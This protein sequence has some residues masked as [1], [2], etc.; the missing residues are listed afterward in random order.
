LE[1]AVES[2]K[3]IKKRIIAEIMAGSSGSKLLGE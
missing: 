3:A 1:R 2:K